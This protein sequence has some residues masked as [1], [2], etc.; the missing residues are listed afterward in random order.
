MPHLTHAFH[1]VCRCP[2]CALPMHIDAFKSDSL[3]RIAMCVSERCLDC[4][5]AWQIDL[6]SG[7]GVSDRPREEAPRV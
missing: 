4:G 1:I 2:R 7:V 6:T 5:F 3:T